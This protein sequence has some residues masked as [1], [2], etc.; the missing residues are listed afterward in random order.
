MPP[1]NTH[2]LYAYEGCN[3]KWFQLIEQSI[4]K[5][6]RFQKRSKILPR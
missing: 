1:R 2:L 3:L 6:K 4:A 5:V